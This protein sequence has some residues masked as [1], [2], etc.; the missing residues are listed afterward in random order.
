MAGGLAPNGTEAIAAAW[1]RLCGEYSG[2]L[3]DLAKRKALA[4][5]ELAAIREELPAC[6][7]LRVL[8]A[9]CGPAWHGVQLALDGHQVVMTDASSKMLAKARSS[10]DA[11][12]LTERVVIR[13]ED[14]RASSLE[15]AS[16]DAVVSC[17]TVVS[18]CGNADAAL[19]EFGRLLRF[20]GMAVFSVRN[21]AALPGRPGPAADVGEPPSHTEVGRH[22]VPQGHEA[23]DWAFFTAEGL[24]SYPVGVVAPPADDA[25]VPGYV[26]LHLELRDDAE[27]LGQARELLAVAQKQAGP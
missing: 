16:I 5:V 19:S 20:G 25:G 24:K 3:A 2:Q 1:D 17:G 15:P 8:D 22:I 18:D 13:R 26:Q 14:I 10:V 6:K 11:A 7:A 21:L 4:A 23:F 9:G 27:A 12:H